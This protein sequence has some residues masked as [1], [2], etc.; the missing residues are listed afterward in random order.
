[1]K[2][3]AIYGAG[4]FGREVACLLK[5][6]NKERP[7]WSFLGF[8]DDGFEIGDSNTHGKILGGINEL[9]SYPKEMSVFVAIGKPSTVKAVVHKIENP[10]ISFPNI[11]SPDAFFSDKDS[12]S[13][14]QGNLIGYRCGV[15][16]DVSIGDFNIFNSDIMIG[17][18]VVINDY[19]VF[20]PSVR[21]S[22]EVSIGSGN[23]LGVGSIILQQKKIGNNVTVGA[24][25]LIIK[26]TKDN[27]TYVG[28]PAV[29]FNI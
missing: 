22:G 9:N 17:H 2:D 7:T 8:F 23:L 3:I 29:M 27:S 20:N 1:M 10:L 25:S 13:I 15:S 28:N 19:N 11:I 14:G 4:G 26:N 21:V 18:D 16:C 5:N 12:F 6:I 24:N